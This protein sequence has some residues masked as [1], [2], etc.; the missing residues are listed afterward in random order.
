MSLNK[1]ELEIYDAVKWGDAK[2]VNAV[3]DACPEAAIDINK[4]NPKDVRTQ[5]PTHTPKDSIEPPVHLN[6][7]CLLGVPVSFRTGS[8]HFRSQQAEVTWT[9]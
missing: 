5:Q 3:L 4:H 2:K 9:L 8:A 7:I 1:K 6:S